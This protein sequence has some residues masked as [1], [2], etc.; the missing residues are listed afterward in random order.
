MFARRTQVTTDTDIEAF[1]KLQQTFLRYLFANIT[2]IQYGL[3]CCNHSLLTVAQ[4]TLNILET[5]N[6]RRF[7][8]MVVAKNL[9]YLLENVDDMAHF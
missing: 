2:Y 4:G 8:N 9:E 7:L 5:A 1:L 6:I 3:F